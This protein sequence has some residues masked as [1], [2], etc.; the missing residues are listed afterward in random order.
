MKNINLLLQDATDVLD[1]LN[2]A[3]E[4]ISSIR[5]NSRLTG[6]WGRCYRRNGIYWIELNPILGNDNVSWEDAL[7]TVIHE[8]L[9]AHKDRFCHTGEWK[10]CAK[11]INKE[12]PIYNIVRTTSAE[13]KG[14]A[15][16]IAPKSYKYEIHCLNC[17]LV[18]KYMREGKI[19]KLI[20]QNPHSCK[21]GKCGA[22]NFKL[23]SY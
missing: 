14:V 1:D 6:C 12:Y 17:G 20:R 2:I 9:H 22:S 4:P 15:D 13:E 7:N 11:L 18:D 8:V 3:Y 5:W 16:L 23:I 19:V 21:C 10:R